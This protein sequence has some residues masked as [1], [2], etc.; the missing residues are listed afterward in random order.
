[1]QDTGFLELTAEL[2]IAVLGFSAIVVAL[3]NRASK[4]SK[5]LD[6]VRFTGMIRS[7]SLVLF[8]SILPFPFVSAG[9]SSAQVWGWSSGIGA[10]AACASLAFDL[11][12]VAHE[13]PWSNAEFNKVF[14]LYSVLAV[15][16]SPVVLVANAIGVV[17]ERTFT[18]YL[19]VVLAILWASLMSFGLL[20]R[21]V[22]VNNKPAA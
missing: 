10:V 1:M 21:S 2:A 17:L 7:S 11:R 8:L 5:N 6:R 14:G 18:P 3:G 12:S 16:G 9:M 4:E 22:F 13:R 15:Y 20:L 19:V